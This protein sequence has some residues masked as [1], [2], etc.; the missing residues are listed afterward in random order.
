Q[1]A[2]YEAAFMFETPIG[3]VCCP[4]SSLE[5]RELSERV[6][7]I[8]SIIRIIEHSEKER[9]REVLNLDK[10]KQYHEQYP[11]YE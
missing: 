11:D 2:I 4:P 5:M 6:N 9:K 10:A 8:Q 1:T 7:R 3:S